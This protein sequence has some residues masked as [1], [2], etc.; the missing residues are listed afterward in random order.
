MEREIYPILSPNISI[1]KLKNDTVLLIN[2]ALLKFKTFNREQSQI[3]MKCNGINSINSIIRDL[4]IIDPN[5]Y[6]EERIMDCQHF[7]KQLF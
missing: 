1:S 5:T 3:I 2:G 4:N 7:F 6:T